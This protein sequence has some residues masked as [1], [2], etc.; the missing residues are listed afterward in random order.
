M[1][2]TPRSK[3]L[4]PKTPNTKPKC[5]RHHLC[6]GP[7]SQIPNDAQSLCYAHIHNS[8]EPQLCNVYLCTRLQLPPKPLKDATPRSEQIQQISLS[9]GVMQ[10]VVWNRRTKDPL[11][12]LTYKP[13]VR[14]T[15]NAVEEIAKSMLQGPE[16]DDM[17]YCKP[18]RAEA[19]ANLGY[20]DLQVWRPQLALP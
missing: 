3:P 6:L 4:E 13:T 2:S 9:S 7:K 18:W 14:N 17:K 19:A 20:A 5:P 15:H 10:D 11:P 16:A 1:C 12:S 8:P